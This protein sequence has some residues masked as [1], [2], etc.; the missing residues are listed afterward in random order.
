[1]GEKKARGLKIARENEG[2]GSTLDVCGRRKVTSKESSQTKTFFSEK[3][4]LFLR[5]PYT[6]EQAVPL[7]QTT[8]IL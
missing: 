3:S 5:Q 1:M 7:G 6:V 2:F 4:G 8:D